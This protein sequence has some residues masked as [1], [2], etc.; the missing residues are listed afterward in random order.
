MIVFPLS[1]VSLTRSHTGR[2]T[3]DMDNN[4][5]QTHDRHHMTDDFVVIYL[6]LNFLVRN[7]II[8]Y[9]VCI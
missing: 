6:L 8:S 2:S 1:Y 9:A 4:Y 3:S 5:W 7:S